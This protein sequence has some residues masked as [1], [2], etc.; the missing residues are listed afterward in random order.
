MISEAF[1]KAKSLCYVRFQQI[2][3]LILLS[4]PFY[5][6][7]TPNRAYHHMASHKGYRSAELVADDVLHLAGVVL[8]I[9]GAIGLAVLGPPGEW[10]ALAIYGAGLVTMLSARRCKICG[11][12]GR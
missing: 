2:T 3:L 8:G 7:P 6:Y 9:A 1:C 10:P 4:D 11:R 12:I 5:T